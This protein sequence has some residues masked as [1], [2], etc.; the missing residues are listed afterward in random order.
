MAGG[1]GQRMH[2]E[3]PKQFIV[4]DDA[5][6]IVH[7]LRT[8][9]DH[10]MI[11]EIAI[12]CI[13][14]RREQ[15]QN[16]VQQ[17]GLEKVTHIFA[18]GETSHHSISNGIRGLVAAGCSATD[19]I[20]VHD[21]VRPLIT[22]RIISENI[23]VC[24]EKGNAVTVVKG[25]E[26]FLYST[27][28]ISSDTYYPRESMYKVQTPHTFCL[29]HIVEALDEADRRQLIG[30]SLYVLMA[31]LGKYPFYFVAG[32]QRNFKLTYPEDLVFLEIFLKENQNT[33][34]IE[35]KDK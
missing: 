22:P 9:E 26:S 29:S 8:F 12:V 34:N 25:S 5:P 3:L 11:D 17:Y 35:M 19:V 1:S 31:E 7:T 15:M 30:Q 13:E 2:D 28:G 33:E 21:G 10:P 18:G 27:D 24:R 20:L 16:L 4:V 6:V 23:R 14:D 32:E